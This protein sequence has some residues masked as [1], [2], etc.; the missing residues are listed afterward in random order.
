MK[1][2]AV[3]ISLMVI[4]NVV[5]AFS[6]SGHIWITEKFFEKYPNN[7]VVRL[8]SDYKREFRAGSI[9]PDITV[10]FY[11]TEGGK[12]Y[13][14]THNWNFQQRVMTQA[15]NDAERCYAWGIASHLISDAHVHNG[16]IADE[17]QSKLIP[18]IPLHPLIEAQDELYLQ[19]NDRITVDI[20]SQSLRIMQDNPRL[21]EIT[22]N[23]LGQGS[24]INV[25]SLT[26]ELS[27]VLGDFYSSAYVPSNPS[28]FYGIWKFLGNT[29]S[30][31]PQQM[32]ISRD[33]SVDDHDKIFRNFALRFSC[34]QDFCPAEPH[35]FNRLE[36]VEGQAALFRALGIIV[37]VVIGFILIKSKR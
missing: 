7:D 2:L 24:P 31:D 18:N 27:S 3:I 14:A 26:A 17:I 28:M 34:D 20:M 13:L 5:L 4:G 12:N 30:I 19:R 22:Q 11:F 1:Y 33:G 21:V 15:V 8:C 36:Y 6:P 32:I 37:I 35:G 10:F 23:A 16:F 29:I 25:K 9:M